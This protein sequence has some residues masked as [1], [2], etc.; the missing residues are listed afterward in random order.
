[1]HYYWS[2][3]WNRVLLI[4]PNIRTM[5]MT[6]RFL[7][8]PLGLEYLKSQVNGLVE[9]DI[10]DAR[11]LKLSHREIRDRIAEYRPDLVGIS[12]NISCGID[13]GIHIARI[14]K[15]TLGNCTVVFGGWHPSLMTDEVLKSA[16]VDAIVCGEGEVTFQA[17]IKNQ[18]FEN[19]PGV[20]YVAD[21]TIIHNE[22]RP[23]VDNLDQLG[24]PD[25]DY[26]R[27]EQFNIMGIPLDVVETSRGC[28]YSCN[29]CCI[30]EFY[31]HTYRIRSSLHIIQELYKI[32]KIAKAT[33]ILIV[34][35]NFLVNINHV[36]ELCH[37]IIKSKLDFHFIAQ[38]RVD[39]IAHH[40]DVIALMAQAGFWCFFI[41]I[42]S[43]T[44]KGLTA[45]NKRV[46]VSNVEKAVKICH[47][48]HIILIGNIIIGVDL[49]GTRLEVLEEIRR[50]Q[51]LSVD[52]LL[53]SMITPLPKTKFYYQ[54]DEENLFVSK[55]WREYNVATPVI[56]TRVLSPEDL[57]EL[58]RI[59]NGGTFLKWK[60]KTLF[61]RILKSRGLRFVLINGFKALRFLGRLVITAIP[62]LQATDGQLRATKNR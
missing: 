37:L 21:G 50:S 20:S 23:L 60:Y 27:V 19:V 52:F 14:T 40:P 57:G 8:P 15:S 29:F 5:I 9:V 51:A 7:I 58:H 54:C 13:E 28:P 33:D 39:S 42:E 61:S 55:K 35:D 56:R 49:D 30:H 53:Y 48:N 36:K 62:Y 2:T 26:R 47:D 12:I 59:A 43:T 44:T 4:Y 22:S 34:D 3:M 11:N 1:M 41:G 45:A 16:F 32:K 10:L 31:H 24:F 6:D 17:I 46:D 25:R 18:S 38:I